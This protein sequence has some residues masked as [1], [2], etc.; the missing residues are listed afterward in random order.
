MAMLGWEHFNKIIGKT[1]K[2]K[3]I[4]LSTCMAIHK[5]FSS[6]DTW[7]NSPLLFT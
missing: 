5:S 2:I 7:W 6:S 3:Y 4:M 1:S